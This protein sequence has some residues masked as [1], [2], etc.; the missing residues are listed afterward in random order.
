[1]NARITQA[2]LLD[3]SNEHHGNQVDIRI[4]NGIIT[5]I[6]SSLDPKNGEEQLQFEN[7]IVSAGWFDSSVSIG[8]PGYE[9]RETILNGLKVAAKSGFTSIAVNPN[10]LPVTDTNAAVS[11]LKNKA[12]GNAVALYPIGALTRNAEGT[13]LA[14]L[15]DMQ[16]AGAVAFGDYQHSISNPNLIKIALQYA[17]GFDGLVLSFPQE[18]DLIIK[19]VANEGETAIKLGLKGIPALSEHIQVAR[20][21]YILEYT[22]GKLHIPTISTAQSVALIKEAKAKG[23]DVTCSVAIANLFYTEEV[24]EDFDT[25]YKVLPP[26]R[27]ETDRQALIAAIKEG[28]I[29][30]V[31]SDHNPLDIELKK[32]EFDHAKFGTIAQEATLGALLTL[33][34]E[35]RAVKLLTAGSERFTG[36]TS[37][38]KIGQPANLSLFTANG[39]SVFGKEDIRSKSKNSAFLGAQLKGKVYGIFANNQFIA[40]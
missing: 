33:V 26:L 11:F 7:L 31:T 13:D 30:M 25:R 9:E 17:Q 10:T 5:E 2:T 8:E 29:D 19:G 4:E 35:E 3:E 14:E 15:Y 12:A 37:K 40:S 38:I 22:G 24:L 16:Q 32:L 18:N 23:L 28:T 36:T 34:S 20:D 39:T 1:M 21:L 27:T 6:A